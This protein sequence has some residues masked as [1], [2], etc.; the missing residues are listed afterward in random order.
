MKTTRVNPAKASLVAELKDILS[1]SKSVAVVDY[2]GLKVSQA[3]ELRRAIRKAGGQILVT[4]NTLFSIAAGLKDLKLDG[5][6][7]FVFSLTDEVSAIKALADFAKSPAVAGLPTFK[8]GFLSDKVLNRD[9]IA[10]LAELPSKDI[11]ISRVLGGLNS[12][13]SKLVYDLNW[14]LSKLVRTLDAVRAKKVN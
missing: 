7:A 13:I 4:K 11:L 10:A 6:S 3:T 1:T 2:K 9:E 5:P 12:P 14:N 8:M